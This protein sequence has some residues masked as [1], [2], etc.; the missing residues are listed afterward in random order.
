[1]GSRSK[2]G[3]WWVIALIL[4]STVTSAQR[5][6]HI[7][8][9]DTLGNP[10]I[11]VPVNLVPPLLGVTY[12]K[13]WSNA[14]G[15]A[16]F[17]QLYFFDTLMVVIEDSRYVPATAILPPGTDTLS[18]ELLRLS[19][20]LPTAEVSAERVAMTVAGDTITFDPRAYALGNESTLGDLIRRIPDLELTETGE[21]LYRGERVSAVLVAG[22]DIFSG[23]QRSA[24][25][26]ILAEHVDRIKII[27]NY[28]GFGDFLSGAEKRVVM[29]V[30]LTDSATARWLGTGELGVGTRGA[31]RGAGNLTRAAETGGTNALLNLRRDGRPALTR[32]DYLNARGSLL[33][34]PPQRATN[35]EIDNLL[36]AGILPPNGLNRSADGLAVLGVRKSN[37]RNRSSANLLLTGN[38]RQAGRRS[39]FF[40]PTLGQDG[41]PVS[42]TEQQANRYGYG[43]LSAGKEYGTDVTD[44]ERRGGF[45]LLVEGTDSRLG[46]RRQNAG[47]AADGT[48]TTED[49][50]TEA[51]AQ[52]FLIHA[53]RRNLRRKSTVTVGHRYQQTELLRDAP[54]RAPLPEQLSPGKFRTNQWRTSFSHAVDARH[55][56]LWLYGKVTGGQSRLSTSDTVSNESGD[57]RLDLDLRASYQLGYWRPSVSMQGAVRRRYAGGALR[58]QLPVNVNLFL[59]WEKSKLHYAQLRLAGGRFATAT[60]RQSSRLPLVVRPYEVRLN[61]ADPFLNSH[62]REIGLDYFA[63]SLLATPVTLLLT[64]TQRWSARDQVEVVTTNYPWL[65]RRFLPLEN[66]VGRSGTL[67]IIWPI[68]PWLKLNTFAT[69][70]EHRQPR[71][72]VTGRPFH[73]RQVVQRAEV[74]LPKLGP[75][76]IGLHYHRTRTRQRLAP[77]ELSFYQQRVGVD[78][79]L[80]L[81]KHW[82][83]DLT[84]G[85]RWS[86]VGAGRSTRPLVN[87]PASVEVGFR[88][89]GSPVTFFARAVEPFNLTP[90]EEQEARLG[91]LEGTTASYGAFPGYFHL[92]GKVAW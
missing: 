21:V 71:A 73:F 63:R 69:L 80:I 42:V 26:G 25:G 61:D 40:D 64:A 32:S 55:E 88:S 62:A 87:Y 1:M 28:R 22:Q 15:V 70:T 36:P 10:A 23:I 66:A 38:Q 3:S 58:T 86:R 35:F 8:L 44:R 46:I 48:I 89:E 76:E 77:T 78:L 68:A 74:S 4:F 72:P 13:G 41:A 83:V 90:R 59:R 51:T 17:P 24:T 34:L 20:E 92:G 18:V 6:V 84:A 27:E 19:A 47:T 5:R 60:L 75:A 53:E 85:L 16:E 12:A 56:K 79:G 29:D 50:R 30:A 39:R 11:G 7:E 14:N 49:L 54:H 33:P 67:R 82:T 65:T 43:L 52:A 2:A 9:R 37:G 31:H 91:D 45:A 57:V 81:P